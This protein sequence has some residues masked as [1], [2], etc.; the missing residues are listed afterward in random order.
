MA[1]MP[2]TASDRRSEYDW[3]QFNLVWVLVWRSGMR[4]SLLTTGTVQDTCPQ[5]LREGSESSDMPPCPHPVH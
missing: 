1:Q 4:E 5:T 3:W 2:A